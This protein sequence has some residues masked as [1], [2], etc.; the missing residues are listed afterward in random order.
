MNTT[1]KWQFTSY[2]RD[3]E[4]GNDYATARYH[5]NRIGRFASPDPLAGSIADPQS[6]N[7]YAYVGNDPVDAIDPLGLLDEPTCIALGFPTCGGGG[8]GEDDGAGYNPDCPPDDPCP[9]D[10]ERPPDDPDRFAICEQFP[11]ICN[12]S[13]QPPPGETP[14][15]GRDLGRFNKNRRKLLRDLMTR[16]DCIRFLQSI[17]I[18]SDA[19]A[20]AIENQTPYNGVSSTISE[21]NAGLVSADSINAQR[22]VAAFFSQNNG[23][24]AVAEPNGLS[25]YYR[26]GNIFGTGS[27]APETIAH[28]AIDNDTR[29]NYSAAVYRTPS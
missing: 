14:L 7:R 22:S 21:A 11:E 3:A 10:D 26:P 20:F 13:V 9:P 2:E 8:G 12:P 4:S 15:R 17:G 18:D 24:N 29:F 16:Q 6:L 27:V 19:L 23:V 1:T 5:I 28:E 25:V